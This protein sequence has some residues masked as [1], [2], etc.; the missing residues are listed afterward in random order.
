MKHIVVKSPAHIALAW[1][2]ATAARAE[3]FA[4]GWTSA[5]DG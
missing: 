5:E 2:L 1:S 3:S 4:K